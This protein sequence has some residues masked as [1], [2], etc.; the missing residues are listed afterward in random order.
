MQLKL[1]AFCGSGKQRP[2][3]MAKTHEQ[4]QNY[5]KTWKKTGFNIREAESAVFSIL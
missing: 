3:E 4:G 5:P 1:I 2:F